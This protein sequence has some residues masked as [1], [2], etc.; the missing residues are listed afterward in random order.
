MFI[1]NIINVIE[2]YIFYFYN[3][4]LDVFID[5]KFTKKHKYF[6]KTYIGPVTGPKCVPK[7]GIQGRLDQLNNYASH[8]PMC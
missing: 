4:R 8:Y 5:T 6:I 1:I 2:I 3:N 7:I